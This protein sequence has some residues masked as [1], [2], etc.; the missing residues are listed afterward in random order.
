ML[1]GAIAS[2][3]PLRK[4]KRRW[5]KGWLGVRRAADPKVKRDEVMLQRR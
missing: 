5:M 3:K 2:S 4:D 1:L